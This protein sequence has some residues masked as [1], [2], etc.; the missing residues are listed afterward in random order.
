M[1]DIRQ[2]RV[3]TVYL[4][5]SQVDYSLELFSFPVSGGQM[6]QR[7]AIMSPLAALWDLDPE[8]DLEFIIANPSSYTY[9]TPERYRYNCGDCTCSSQNCTCDQNCKPP[10]Y[11]TLGRPTST[12]A[13]KLY[14]CYQWNY[15]RWPYGIGSFSDKNGRY[16][17]YALRDGLLGVERARRIY[18]KLHVVYMV[19][20][21]DTCNDGLPTCD[22]SCW[23]RN[24]WDVDAGEAKC[25][26]NQMDI[27]CPAMLQG[28][29][30]KARGHQY[31]KYLESLY[32][33]PVHKLHTIP[34]VG[35]N[36]TAMF[37]SKIGL[38]ELFGFS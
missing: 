32:G 19:G 10:P 27:R 24:H 11:S 30:R 29:Y 14:P 4:Q 15:D 25:W 12:Y 34:G 7:Y 22:S 3:A 21:N 13:G 31:M 6:V 23:K 2:V 38:E 18:P 9:L 17:P 33:H 5:D 1:W 28:P 26:R 8:V 20:Q 37:G 35:H 36:A 16:I